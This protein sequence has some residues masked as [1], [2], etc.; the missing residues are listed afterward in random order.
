[1]VDL[2]EKQHYRQRLK[3][4]PP[5]AVGEVAPSPVVYPSR[6]VFD[7]APVPVLGVVYLAV[8]SFQRSIGV[9]SISTYTF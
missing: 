1:M 5:K 8:A 6:V 9:D 7:P 3:K 4:A 2:L